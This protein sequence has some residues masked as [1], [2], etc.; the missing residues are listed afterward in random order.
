MVK[1]V[2]VSQVFITLTNYDC[3]VKIQFEVFSSSDM[4]NS[5]ALAPVVDSTTYYRRL[6]SSEYKC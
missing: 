2:Q 4:E 3:L 1:L 6:F 5:S